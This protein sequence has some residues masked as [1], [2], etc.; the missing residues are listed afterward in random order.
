[1]LTDVGSGHSLG[2]KLGPR[3]WAL[4]D[5]A[6]SSCGVCFMPHSGEVVELRFYP[7]LSGFC[8]VVN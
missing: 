4:C 2:G 1:M 5:V 3:D 8:L 7:S 6:I